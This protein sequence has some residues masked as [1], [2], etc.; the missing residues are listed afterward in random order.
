MMEIIKKEYT[1]ICKQLPKL[2]KS[3]LDLYELICNCCKNNQTL[4]VTEAFIIYKKHGAGQSWNDYLKYDKEND[5]WIGGVRIWNDYIWKQ[6]FKLWILHTLGAL[7][8]KGYL[9]VLPTIDFSELLNNN[10]GDGGV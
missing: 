8:W 7:L 1:Q 2:R 6:N 9:T 4:N 3:Q 10:T 5:R